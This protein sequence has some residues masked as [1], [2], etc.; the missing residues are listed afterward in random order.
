M[1]GWFEEDQSFSGY[2]SHFN[3]WNRVLSDKEIKDLSNCEGG[4]LTGDVLDWNST[5]TEWELNKVTQ[6]SI[7]SSELCDRPVNRSFYM[8]PEN[9]SLEDAAFVCTTFGIFNL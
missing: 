3:I 8:L 6:E 2:I 9:R 4:S 7:E 5:N 1:G